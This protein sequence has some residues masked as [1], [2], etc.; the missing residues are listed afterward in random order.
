MTPD[1]VLVLGTGRCGSTLLSAML[2]DHP[3]FLSVSE[4]FSFLTDLGLEISRALPDAP[5][6]GAAF[7]SLLADPRP[8]QSILLRH[9]LQMDEVIYPWEG[10]RFTAAAG[11]PPVLQAMLPH[12]EPHNPDVLFDLLAANVPSWP[13]RAAADHYRALFALLAEVHGR[14][15]WAERSG[16]SLRVA[17]RLLR[18]FPEARVLHVVRD[19]RNTA[20]SMSR[21]IGFRMALIAAQQ[22]ELLGV[23]PYTSTDRSEEDDLPDDLVALLPERFSAEAFRAFNLPTMLCGHYWSGEIVEGLQTLSAV[24]AGRLLTVRYEDLI[25]APGPTLERVAAF[26]DP[27]IDA[28]DWVRSS[29]ARVGQGRSAWQDLPPRLRGEL[30]EACRRGF[31]ALDAIGLRWDAA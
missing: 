27:E 5:L 21:H 13:F 30:D 18:A 17:A 6:D 31:E 8:R 15:S 4:L 1:P 14:R 26:L 12:L 25:E 24:P 29:A 23:D 28:S 19:G 7:W 20:L 22:L 11:V 10:G 2:R 3:T 9:G 16:G